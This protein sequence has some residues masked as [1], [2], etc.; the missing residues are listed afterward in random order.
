MALKQQ[1]IA[2]AKCIIIILNSAYFAALASFI[3]HEAGG[4]R[5]HMLSLSY[6]P[7]MCK[8]AEHMLRVYIMY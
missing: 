5:G 1:D 6:T 2:A 3:K 4:G 7:S 8:H